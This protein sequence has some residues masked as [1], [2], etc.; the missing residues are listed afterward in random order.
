MWSS[1]LPR[2]LRLER[3]SYHAHSYNIL[4]DKMGDTE[5]S[6]YIAR[7]TGYHTELAG[8]YQIKPWWK[9]LLTFLS[10]KFH[11]I[12]HL[13]FIWNNPRAIADLTLDYVRNTLLDHEAQVSLD[14]PAV[15]TTA[16][17]TTASKPKPKPK[18]QPGRQGQKKKDQSNREHKW[19]DRRQTPSRDITCYYC[20]MNRHYEA[21]CR[22]KKKCKEFR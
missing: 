12:R 6:A 10:P 14:T 21:D 17:T 22:L 19:K 13:N 1:D 18:R 16:L 20:L 3:Y 8:S 2:C 4:N 5:T 9:H 11:N 7:L 15:E